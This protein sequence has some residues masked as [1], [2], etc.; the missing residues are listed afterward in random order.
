MDIVVVGEGILTQYL[1]NNWKQKLWRVVRR[2]V[3][4]ISSFCSCNFVTAR[5]MECHFNYARSVHMK[6]LVCVLHPVGLLLTGCNTTILVA[7]S[8]GESKHHLE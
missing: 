2:F 1:N 6:R 7:T 4:A 3:C 8:L 5:C